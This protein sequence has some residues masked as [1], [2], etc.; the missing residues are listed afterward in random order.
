MASTVH[1]GAPISYNDPLI[2]HLWSE[3]IMYSKSIRTR[4]LRHRGT[5]R[6]LLLWFERRSDLSALTWNYRNTQ[7]ELSMLVCF[8]RYCKDA[9]PRRK[10]GYFLLFA[11]SPIHIIF[12]E[13][14]IDIQ[15]VVVAVR[16]RG[17]GK[18]KGEATSSLRWSQ[19]WLRLRQ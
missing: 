15:A 1:W 5:S 14:V 13:Y 10:S 19:L 17:V 4:R 8:I 6:W 11:V 12:K 2:S 18:R 9:F 3:R 16:S 7:N